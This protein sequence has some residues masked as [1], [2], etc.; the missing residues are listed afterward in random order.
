MNE[1]RKV[2]RIAGWIAA[3]EAEIDRLAA[4]MAR[5]E[6]VRQRYRHNLGTMQRLYDDCAAA[7]GAALP[8]LAQNQAGY[9]QTLLDAVTQLRAAL[10]VQEDNLEV[11][12]A[13][14]AAKTLRCEVW[15]RELDRRRRALDLARRRSEQRA[16]DELA[17]QAWR[18]TSA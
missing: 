7:T 15:R 2:T 4:D 13:L 14:L 9:R 17:A 8:M 6:A 10:K 3:R 18:R 12:R 11:G 16:Q 1:Q 5:Q